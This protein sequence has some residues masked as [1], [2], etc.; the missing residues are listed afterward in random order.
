INMS[1]KTVEIFGQTS[2]YWDNKRHLLNESTDS[3]LK[4]DFKSVWDQG[5]ISPRIYFDIFDK[6]FVVLRSNDLGSIM[7]NYVLFAELRKGKGKTLL[8]VNM[9]CSYTIDEESPEAPNSSGRPFA[10]LLNIP[11]G[12][13]ES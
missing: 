7:E 9:T 8:D 5:D 2:I 13:Y 11:S 4:I 10:K 3:V 6:K 1:E 12:W